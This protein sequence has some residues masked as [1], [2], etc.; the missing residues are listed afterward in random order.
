MQ[1]PSKVIQLIVGLLQAGDIDL[2]GNDI[3]LSQACA[4]K[5]HAAIRRVANLLRD[6]H[7]NCK[8]VDSPQFLRES[9]SKSSAYVAMAS[10]LQDSP[11]RKKEFQARLTDSFFRIERDDEIFSLVAEQYHSQLLEARAALIAAART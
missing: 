3:L 6:I 8:L 1:T 10:R 7:V 4:P 5:H 2:L 9:A 11:I